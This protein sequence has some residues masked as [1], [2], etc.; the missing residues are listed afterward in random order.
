LL[1]F[2][3]HH[4]TR[5]GVDVQS[6]FAAGTDYGKAIWITHGFRFLD[7]AFA[8]TF[9]PWLFEA[10]IIAVTGAAKPAR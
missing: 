9:D 4:R 6:A 5:L 10:D 3:R 2:M 7:A 8:R 1:L